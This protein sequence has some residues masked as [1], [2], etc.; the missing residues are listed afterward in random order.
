[1]LPQCLL[2][3]TALAS[4][5]NVEPTSPSVPVLCVA[6]AAAP[7]TLL[8]PLPVIELVAALRARLSPQ[9]VRVLACDPET[10]DVEPTWRLLARR[11]D[12]DIIELVVEGTDLSLRHEVL[13]GGRGDHEVMQIL[14]LAGVEAVRPAAAALLAKVS[15]EPAAS[16]DL[17]ESMAHLEGQA[18]AT[19]R[20]PWLRGGWVV[21]PRMATRNG[22]LS[23]ATELRVD[24]PAGGAAIRV[25]GGVDVMAPQRAAGV[26]VRGEQFEAGFGLVATWGMLEG[27][28]GV[29]GRLANLRF[30]SSTA[31]LDTTSVQFWSAGVGAHVG[32]W[33]WRL[34]A[35][36]FGLVG[37]TWLWWR[38]L[39]LRRQG[40]KVLVQSPVDVLV[41]P[42]VS[43]EWR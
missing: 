35:W 30:A 17:A 9:Q 37:R 36:Q 10:T 3:W 7:E 42:A 33:P 26:R 31:A 20:S 21:G 11:R 24:V 12:A 8:G 43:F 13:V 16:D 5:P 19:Q 28:L 4:A 22:V 32:L 39:R 29:Q 15:P 2:V 23:G 41:G 18:T 40:E 25:H 27:G 6:S 1:M 14:A 38:L 34:G